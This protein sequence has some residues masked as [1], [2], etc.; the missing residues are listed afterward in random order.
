[1][2]AQ[3]L[4][5]IASLAVLAGAS[6]CPVFKCT[7]KSLKENQCISHDLKA[8]IYK[9]SLCPSGKVCDYFSNPLQEE[10]F[11]SQQE[12]QKVHGEECDFNNDCYSNSCEAKAC[13]GFSK[14]KECTDTNQCELGLYCNLTKK[15]C[16]PQVS[17]NEDCVDDTDCLNNLGCNQGKCKKYVS[18][19][20]GEASDSYLLCK[21][22]FA[23]EGKCASLKLNK[24]SDECAEG[25]KCGYT[26]SNG[27]EKELVKE[28]KCSRG[29]ETK[30]YCE[31]DTDSSLWKE[32]ISNVKSFYDKNSEFHSVRRNN[33]DSKTKRS[34]YIA[35]NYPKYKN[36]DEC[37]IAIDVDAQGNEGRWTTRSKYVLLLMFLLI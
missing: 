26:V 37:A 17:E 32:M 36:S 28:C 35:V 9:I 15:T 33:Y 25:E 30:K 27:S 23:Y 10:I 19:E 22:L 21:T 3:S 5:L 2:K 1:M 18:L 6:K 11:C 31:L 4:L 12:K 13:K 34:F 7:D 24:T 16:Q 20:V 29:D 14:D 8:D